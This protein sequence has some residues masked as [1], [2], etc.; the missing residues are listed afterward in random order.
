[1]KSYIKPSLKLQ[2]R[3][4][5]IKKTTPVQIRTNLRAGTAYHQTEHCRTEKGQDPDSIHGM[6]F[7]NE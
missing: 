6:S 5:G 3:Q 2:N 4:A 1:M 7:D